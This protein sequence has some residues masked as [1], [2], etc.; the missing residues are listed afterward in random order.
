MYISSL[1]KYSE[2]VQRSSPKVCTLVYY[3]TNKYLL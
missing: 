3:C 1:E 2:V